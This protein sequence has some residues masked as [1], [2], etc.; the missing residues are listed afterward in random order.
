MGPP[1]YVANYTNR[2]VFLCH[3]R[4]AIGMVLANIDAPYVA[5]FIP[6]GRACFLWGRMECLSR[7]GV[8]LQGLKAISS[9]DHCAT[10][11]IEG[12]SMLGCACRGL[13]GSV[14]HR[15][16]L[17]PAYGQLVPSVN[18][19]Q[20]LNFISLR[21]HPKLTRCQRLA[22]QWQVSGAYGN[23]LLAPWHLLL[24]QDFTPAV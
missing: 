9:L 13:P 12:I 8:M 1:A 6:I 18:E 3:S 17:T 2:I 14:T 22:S 24:R 15:P 19:E 7:S 23:C 20:K 4:P 10:S 16:E 11:T 5:E 21:V